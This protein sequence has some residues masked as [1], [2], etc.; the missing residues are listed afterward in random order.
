[1]GAMEGQGKVKL[2]HIHGNMCIYRRVT[3]Q[4]DI[5]A[6][7]GRALSKIVSCF[8]SK[9]DPGVLNST[10]LSAPDTYLCKDFETDGVEI[11]I[12]NFKELIGL[13]VTR[14]EN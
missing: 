8:C 2:G 5:S 13:H 3:F 4:P 11:I 9:D 12:Y 10:Q 1:M 14:E 6:Y 7:T